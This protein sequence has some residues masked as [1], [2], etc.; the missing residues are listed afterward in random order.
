MDGVT[1]AFSSGIK[2]LISGQM[3]LGE[4]MDSIWDGIV[5]TVVTAVANMAAQ[6][7]VM[8]IMQ[9]LNMGVTTSTQA[10][11]T[12]ANISAAA[13]GYFAAY[14][15]MPYVGT[16]L[17]LAAIATMMTT[18]SALAVAP[19][20][21]GAGK[22]A[23]IAGAAEGG[24]FDRP[25]PAVI[26]EGWQRELVV[27]EVTF[28]QWAGNLANRLVSQASGRGPAMSGANFAGATIFTSNSTEM[29]NF[30]SRASKGYDRRNG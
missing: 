26:G 29:Q 17:A 28:K 18:L 21:S 3:S 5:D 4:A 2:G 25:T 27:P 23:F 30:L 9:L 20:V 22:G 8:Q 11:I 6:W 24:W 7:V 1:N 16:G 12:A 14:A 15:A 19:A 13:S 10:A